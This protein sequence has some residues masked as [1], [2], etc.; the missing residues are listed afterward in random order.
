MQKALLG[1]LALGSKVY[2]RGR[3]NQ[4]IVIYWQMRPC[5]YRRQFKG[6]I[7]VISCW[8]IQ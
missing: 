8:V 3:T 1:F 4:E 5:L 7:G 6:Q 2:S